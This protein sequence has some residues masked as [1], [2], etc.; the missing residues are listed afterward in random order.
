MKESSYPAFL[1]KEPK[2]DSEIMN[3]IREIGVLWK[4]SP[5][6][7]QLSKQVLDKWE[8]VIGEWLE[9]K[10]M[11]LIARK[12]TKTEG[13]GKVISHPS[14]RKIIISDNTFPDWMF[15]NIL[16]GKI[17]ELSELKEM[18][19]N[20]E[21]PIAFSFE[22]WEKTEATYTKTFSENLQFWKVCHIKAV[23]FNSRKS[24]KEIPIEL[25]EEHFRKLANPKNIFLL[26]KQIGALG[27]IQQFI[28]EQ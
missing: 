15:S 17:Y 5:N 14:G 18:L 27:E 3:K 26:P 25:I 10:S 21:L 19:E 20:N 6:K 22:K 28:D 8:S 2:V 1:K 23:G 12:K 13:R 16:R 11:P 9:D 7:P 4:K 24:I